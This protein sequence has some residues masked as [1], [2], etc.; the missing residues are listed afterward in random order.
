MEEQATEQKQRQEQTMSD[1]QKLMS[2]WGYSFESMCTATDPQ[3]TPD[4]NDVPNTNV[5]YC[6]AVKTR[7][8][9]NTIAMGAEVDCIEGTL[10]CISYGCMSLLLIFMYVVYNRRETKGWQ[11]FT[12][13]CRAQDI[14][15]NGY[16]ETKGKL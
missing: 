6:V 7:L 2:Y 12:A 5:Q 16:P 15:E 8:G 4:P 3:G 11:S 13:L 9:K 10:L 14:K 1:R